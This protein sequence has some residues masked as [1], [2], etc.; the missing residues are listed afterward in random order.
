[1]K[2]HGNDF[3]STA[4]LVTDS[5]KPPPVRNLHPQLLALL[6]I[7]LYTESTFATQHL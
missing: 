7:F 2:W 5:V 1:M 3:T 6:G 4:G